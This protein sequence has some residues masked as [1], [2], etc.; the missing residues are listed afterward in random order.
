MCAIFVSV[1]FWINSLD[2]NVIG[3]YYLA[4]FILTPI[5]F[6]F[7]GRYAQARDRLHVYRAGIVLHGCYYAL[8][9]YLGAD[10]AT[11]SLALGVLLGITWGVYWPGSNTIS[12]D[13]TSQ[14]KRDY[15]FGTLQSITGLAKLL[16][17]LIAGAIISFAPEKDSGY[18][19][20]FGV[21]LGIYLLI[22]LLT[23]RIPHD[24]ESRPFHLRRALFPGRDQRDWQLIMLA[25]ATLA[26]SFHIFEI[27]L[28]LLMYMNTGD[29]MKV[30]GF[31][32]F[33]GLASVSI[34]YIIGRMMTPH[35]RKRSML[36]G[37]LLIF[38]GGVIIL[39]KFNL[40]TL[41]LFGFLRAVGQPLFG[42]PHFSIRLDIIGRSIR[43]PWE[44]IE[45]LCAWEVPLAIGRVVMFLAILG[46]YHVL[47]QS[48]F[49]LRVG[50]FALCCI[51]LMTY[52][53]LIHTTDIRNA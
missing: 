49:G 50:L 4:L 51:R 30:G 9:L 39:L 8:L 10:A 2:L 34:A 43:E 33:Q 16:A 53:I 5:V 24:R 48:E 19:M 29:E 23:F 21:V 27:L 32:A 22:F 38:L 7:A 28:G 31:A 20:L 42:I 18:R 1:Y 17:P 13:V 47:Q 25:S 14:G 37:T 6:Q 46:F 44:R 36:A 40:Y 15:Y 35:T 11:H 3:R 26:G 41:I 45:Y 12:F 52:Y